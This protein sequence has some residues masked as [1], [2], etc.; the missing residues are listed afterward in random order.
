[1]RDVSIIIPSYNRPDDLE[2][3]LPFYFVQDDVK[4]II[5]IDDGSSKSYERIVEK[6]EN[7]RKGEVKFIYYK[8]P[9][10]SGAGASR[11]KGLELATG[12]YILWGEDDA[13]LAPEYVKVLKSK[14][15][16]D[17]LVFGSIYYGI[18]PT[19]LDSEKKE[20]IK[21]QQNSKRLLFDY[22][23]LEGYYRIINSEDVLVPWG[24]AL[25]MV[26]KDAYANVKYF[27]G[28]AVN[29]YREETDAQIQIVKAG[30]SAIYTSDTCCYHFPAKNSNGGQ[31][32]ANFFVFEFYKI[33]NNNIFLRRHY[34]FLRKHFGLKK[35]LFGMECVFVFN[36][37]KLC[38]V[39]VINKLKRK[40]LQ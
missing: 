32:S 22:D 11:N 31:H 39:K 20:I 29:G 33:K 10:N 14:I 16:S 37:V 40:M 26:R 36:E 23:L 18:H 5:I 4:E 15:S 7:F 2:I 13:F 25:L 30:Y 27:E 38:V 8:N 9:C 28:Y 24:H 6:Y 34:A 21:V 3:V 12:E 19:M 17:K 35:T 1:M